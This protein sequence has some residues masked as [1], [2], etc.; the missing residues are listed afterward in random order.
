MRDVRFL[1]LGCTARGVACDIFFQKF[2]KMF[3]SDTYYLRVSIELDH[4]PRGRPRSHI[5][6]R[7]I[8]KSKVNPFCWCEWHVGGGM[9]AVWIR[10][11]LSIVYSICVA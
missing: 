5:L 10:V 2:S 7:P 3:F 8:V 11:G 9:C 4:A 1:G 6:S